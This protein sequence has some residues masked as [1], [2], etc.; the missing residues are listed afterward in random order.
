MIDLT[1]HESSESVHCATFLSPAEHQPFLVCWAS[2]LPHWLLRSHDR[3]SPVSC[4]VRMKPSFLQVWVEPWHGDL[5]L[6]LTLYICFSLAI[7]LPS[8]CLAAQCPNLVSPLDLAGEGLVPLTW[9]VQLKLGLRPESRTG[10]GPQASVPSA[11][12]G[13]CET[14]LRCVAVLFLTTL[15]RA[16]TSETSS[17]LS[18]CCP[19]IPVLSPRMMES[20]FHSCLFWQYKKSRTWI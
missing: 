8:P 1:H 12:G 14:R 9:M 2:C 3:H 6:F 15:R 11:A 18:L 4:A 17:T 7:W 19:F 5:R 16:F 10:G 13:C 20:K